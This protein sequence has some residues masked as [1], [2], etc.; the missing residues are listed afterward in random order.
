MF[1]KFSMSLWIF[2]LQFLHMAFNISLLLFHS[3]CQVAANYLL[4]IT[5][6]I[7]STSIPTVIAKLTFFIHSPV[8][9]NT[10]KTS[11]FLCSNKKEITIQKLIFYVLQTNNSSSTQPFNLAFFLF[12]NREYW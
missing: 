4:P 6:T 12:H 5:L 8:N 3:P 7:F 2:F 1:T 11:M 9:Q 10:L